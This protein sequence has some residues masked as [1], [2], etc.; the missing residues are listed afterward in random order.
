MQLGVF[1]AENQGFCV[2]SQ[3]LPYDKPIFE[4]SDNAVSKNQGE[5]N[6]NGVTRRTKTKN[7]LQAICENL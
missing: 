6:E 2:F 3:A 4:K 7:G 1:F 5:L